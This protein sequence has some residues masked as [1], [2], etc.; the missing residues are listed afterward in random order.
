MVCTS[1][2]ETTPNSEKVIFKRLLFWDISK[3]AFSSKINSEVPLVFENKFTRLNITCLHVTK[4]RLEQWNI[5]SSIRSCTGALMTVENYCAV[6]IVSK[7]PSNP[8]R[9]APSGNPC[10]CTAGLR[11]NQLLPPITCTVF[12][13][14]CRTMD[15]SLS[16]LVSGAFS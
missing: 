12:F 11:S 2:V 1:H 7:Q 16:K 6:S 5:P 13:P 14:D 10:V 15:Y 4:Q 3:R 9:L 8:E